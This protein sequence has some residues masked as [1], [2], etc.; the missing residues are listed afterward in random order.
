MSQITRDI[1]NSL[2]NLGIGEVFSYKTI[3]NNLII[4]SEYILFNYNIEQN[5]LYVSFHVSV[6]PDASAG[7]ILYL[8][9]HIKNINDI[10]I[11]DSFYFDKDKNILSGKE[12]Y[13]LYDT[14]KEQRIFDLFI[15]D[16]A[17]KEF[18]FHVQGFSC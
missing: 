11:M 7:Y 5:E 8:K 15:A 3:R 14:E 9:E 4:N 12:A 16:R 18:L 17:Q 6:R 2:K 1:S 10:F 13:A